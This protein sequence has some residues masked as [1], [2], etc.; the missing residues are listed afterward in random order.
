MKCLDFVDQI[1]DDI[2]IFNVCRSKNWMGETCGMAFPQ[3]L[4]NR[5]D[6]NKWEFFCKCEW[7]MLLRARAQ[8]QENDQLKIWVDSV[9][10]RYGDDDE[11][12]P[13]L[14]C[15]HKFSPMENGQFPGGGN[16]VG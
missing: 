11:Q 16:E 5:P 12:W 7:S 8:N 3:K 6:P 1:T 13:P 4:W 10:K 15:C 9:I 14:G 2:R